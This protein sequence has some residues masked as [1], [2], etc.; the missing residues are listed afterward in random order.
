[1]ALSPLP[2][3]RLSLSVEA[4]VSV[5][6]IVVAVVLVKRAGGRLSWRGKTRGINADCHYERNH[7]ETTG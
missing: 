2:L 7:F 3:M 6:S 4:P 1:M 5:S